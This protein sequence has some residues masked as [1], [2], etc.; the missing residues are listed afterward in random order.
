MSV[1]PNIDSISALSSSSTPLI[2]KEVIRIESNGHEY[3]LVSHIFAKDQGQV[4]SNAELTGKTQAELIE[5]ALKG[6][7]ADVPAYIA[8]SNVV[9]EETQAS[10]W[11]NLLSVSLKVKSQD[12]TQRTVKVD[13]A[14]LSSQLN[15]FSIQILFHSLMGDLDNYVASKQAELALQHMG[16]VTSDVEKEEV[17][18]RLLANPTLKTKFYEMRAK[19]SAF[20]EKTE[21]IIDKINDK[22]SVNKAPKPVP[23]A[24]PAPNNFEE[25]REKMN[26]FA[27]NPKDLDAFK[28]FASEENLKSILSREN[29]IVNK[30]S[31]QEKSVLLQMMVKNQAE[32]HK[33]NDRELFRTS[34]EAAT[35]LLLP[36]TQLPQN[37]VAI[38]QDK[39]NTLAQSVNIAD[40]TTELIDGHNVP[41][42]ATKNQLTAFVNNLLKFCAEMEVPLEFKN[43]IHQLFNELKNEFLIQENAKNPKDADVR[44]HDRAQKVIANIIYL[45][46]IT[47]L[48]N[49][50]PRK[51]RHCAPL[52]LPAIIRNEALLRNF[53]VPE[54]SFKAREPVSKVAMAATHMQPGPVSLKDFEREQKRVSD[55]IRNVKVQP[56]APTANLQRTRPGL[57]VNRIRPTEGFQQSKDFDGRLLKILNNKPLDSTQMTQDILA[58]F[59]QKDTVSEKFRE[60]LL[61]LRN[62]K[63][64]EIL[65]Q[66]SAVLTQFQQKELAQKKGEEAVRAKLA[67]YVVQY[68]ENLPSPPA[69]KLEDFYQMQ[70]RDENVKTIRKVMQQHDVEASPLHASMVQMTKDLNLVRPTPLK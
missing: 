32:T 45:K 6:K 18:T 19:D 59:S 37:S 12:G 41:T 10:C 56:R 70:Q 69:Q 58:E 54:S 68:L 57:D 3:T 51:I 26:Q 7:E 52:L 42:G 1:D 62:A 36:I 20:T 34:S 29:P 15:V 22:Q 27:Q 9:F 31:P 43:Q 17:A 28:K 23:A 16:N 50:M 53:G 30:L 21:T 4:P 46:M 66:N 25:I 39:M 44:A 60:E 13:S 8:K 33:A 64:K 65:A 35:K 61:L 63:E 24:A 67:E 2:P 48:L 38:L 49:N 5:A 47:P 11:G 55:A 40:F 14:A